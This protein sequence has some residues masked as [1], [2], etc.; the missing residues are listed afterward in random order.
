MWFKRKPKQ[1]DES[2]LI[3]RQSYLN[4]LKQRDFVHASP[5][6]TQAQRDRLDYLVKITYD[7]GSTD[8]DFVEWEKN[9]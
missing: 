3:I 5:A 6:A 9:R 1:P 4:V 8:P 2:Q 7:A